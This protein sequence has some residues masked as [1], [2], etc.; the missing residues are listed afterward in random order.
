MSHPSGATVAE[1]PSI[2]RRNTD[3]DARFKDLRWW[4][5]DK[6]HEAVFSTVK[7]IGNHARARQQQDLYFACLYDDS[8]LAA[9]VQGTQAI[10]S[11]TPQTMTRNIVRRQ[12]DSF[13]AK[14]SKNRPVPMALTTDGNYSQQRR[15][16]ALSKFFE[17][18]LDRVDFWRTRQLRLRDGAIFGSGIAHNYRRG[19]KLY[20][21]RIPTWE[22]RVDPR[23]AMY[24]KPRSFYRI[25]LMDRL[26]ALETYPDH[27][28]DLLKAESQN[29]EDSLVI[30]WD[31][32]CD[33][34]A[35]R[36]AWHLPSGDVEDDD[37]EATDHDGRH[38]VCFSNC[39]PINDPFV[40]DHPP[41]SKFDFSPPVMGWWGEGMTKQLAGLQFEVNAIGL[42]LQENGYMNGT[43]VWV[44][45][46]S[47]LETDVLDNGALSVIRSATEPKFMNPAPW[48]PDFYQYWKDICGPIPAQETRISE[49]TARGEIPPGL[50]SGKAI[51]TYH[52]IGTE[53]FLPQGREDERDVIDTCWQLFDLIEE[54]ADDDDSPAFEVKVESKN[55]GRQALKGV[56]YE[57]VR[58]DRESLTLR[59]FPTN[60]LAGTPED[61]WDQIESM[62]KTGLW[63]EDELLRL[64][65]FPDIQRVLSLKTGPREA[66]EAIFEDMLD[67]DDPKPI[68]PE[69]IM[70]LDLAVAL[71]AL[72]YLQAK[73][74]DKAPETHTKALFDFTMAAMSMK[75][76][77][78]GPPAG[79]PGPMPPGGAPQP[80]GMLPP[81][82]SVGMP[83]PPGAMAPTAM[84]GPHV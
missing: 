37:G 28:E 73:F 34:I 2:R 27:E 10:S 50:E 25:G 39:T 78:A 44:S 35:Y 52:D 36:E 80:P 63:S 83:P 30:G 24:G 77:P 19:G 61:R 54:I 81:K 74:I 3:V 60:F 12:V 14:M 1:R 7:R 84:P 72:Y 46:D 59:T 15:A 4:K 82:P 56:S 8:E 26:V 13:V 75:N 70:N 33:L 11:Y 55:Y 31:D 68:Y 57:K 67:Q 65:D 16:K 18:V 41:L 76:K 49:I 23:E 5:A 53:A 32:T 62:A 69:P 58:M 6:P 51:R 22:L 21:E 71:G 48:H 40:W 79:A 43:Y 66:L 29:I 42:R 64:I 47:G 45:D 17:G 20:H 38:V 9:L